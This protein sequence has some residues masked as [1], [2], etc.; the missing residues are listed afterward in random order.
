MAKGKTALILV[1]VLGVVLAAVGIFILAS[2]GLAEESPGENAVEKILADKLNSYE[3]NGLD[4]KTL[5]LLEEVSIKSADDPRLGV[6]RLILANEIYRHADSAFWEF[7]KANQRPANSMIPDHQGNLALYEKYISELDQITLKT[8]GGGDFLWQAWNNKGNAKVY[9]IFLGFILKEDSKKLEKLAKSALTDYVKA[10]DYCA[11]D[12]DCANFVGQNIDFLTR[13][14][15]K[16][17]GKEGGSQSGG[18]LGS[19]FQKGES[20]QEKDGS[21]Q[22]GSG[23]SGIILPGVSSGK[24]I[25]GAH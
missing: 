17:N 6:Y 25:K 13:I 2:H 16:N 24:S 12:K 7:L 20:G 8:Y 3:T 21:G 9:E 23:R 5:K 15:P 11:Q 19:L 14:P 22:D 18:G 4:D 1:S 10:Y